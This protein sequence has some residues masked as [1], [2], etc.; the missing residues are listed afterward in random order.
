WEETVRTLK[1]DT[2][3]YAKRQMTWF[4]ADPEIVCAE[5][6]QIDYIKEIIKNFLQAEKR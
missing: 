6:E 3:R 4:K 5:P 1:R 2:R